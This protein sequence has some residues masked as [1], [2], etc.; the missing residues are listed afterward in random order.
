MK[1]NMKH[2]F[3]VTTLCLVVC[4]LVLHVC[5][6]EERRTIL[7]SSAAFQLNSKPVFVSSSALYDR[8]EEGILYKEYENT[9]DECYQGYD[10]PDGYMVSGFEQKY[11]AQGSP[12]YIDIVIPNE[13][14]GKPVVGIDSGAFKNHSEIKSITFGK[15]I[16]RIGNDSFYG[17]RAMK[18]II[19]PQSLRDIGPD[20]F[21]KCSGL[22]EIVIPKN[23]V[24]IDTHAFS[25]CT[26]LQTVTFKG[27]PNTIYQ[28]VFRNTKWLKTCR[29]KR[30]A[31]IS[32]RI[33]IDAS[34]LSGHVR[35]T[36]KKVDRVVT[37]AFWNADRIVSLEMRG[38]REISGA[39]SGMGF[40]KSIRKVK[41]DNVEQPQNNMLTNSK[42][43]ETVILG[44]RFSKLPAYCFS[45]C[46]KLKH[47]Y[48]YNN[49]LDA[50]IRDAGLS[51]NVVL[52]V[53]KSA[54]NK[55]KRMAL[56]KVV[57]L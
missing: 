37:G 52:H 25:E 22:T 32:N 40:S 29:Q 12:I 50:S 9:G 34:G 41:L 33:L 36:G 2:N 7:A 49:K 17:C 8:M 16:V 13:I 21:S 45:G 15:N 5:S 46:K 51:K 4:C 28:D 56:C 35:I 10:C 26:G 27:I 23:V 24:I 11:N 3:K 42:K 31:A 1:M 30:I 55:Y 20:A 43:M 14:A 19:L 47:V 44:K 6:Q 18:S 48:V 39:V 57:A 54:I 53:P 38:V